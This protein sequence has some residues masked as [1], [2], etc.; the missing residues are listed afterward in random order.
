LSPFI[1]ISRLSTYIDLLREQV[2]KGVNIE[3][4]TRPAYQQGSADQNEIKNI[5]N[6]L[7]KIG[8]KLTIR[9]HMHQKVIVLDGRLVWFGSLNALSH[10]NT[11]ELMLRL[12]N[13]DFSKQL[14]EECS[15][16][17]PNDKNA[18]RSPAIDSHKIASILCSKCGNNMKVVPKGRFGPFYK[19]EHCN[20]TANIKREDLKKALVAEAIVCPE[21]GRFLELRWGQRGM[22]LGCSG[23][24]D[25]KNQCRYTRPLC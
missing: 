12:E 14:M 10:K 5:F 6:Y 16:Y 9:K 22:F 1:T 21:C 24:K 13:P 18:V 3:I 17:A 4:V 23:Y 7:E 15:L 20:S 8:V 11:Q 2:D 19:C 25:E